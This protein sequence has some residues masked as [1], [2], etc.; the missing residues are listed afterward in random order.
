MFNYKKLK[1][2]TMKKEELERE[3][4]NLRDALNRA[5]DANRDLNDMM[6]QARAV[7]KNQGD[8]INQLE[9][10]LRMREAQKQAS[11]RFNDND[12]NY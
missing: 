5:N 6:N 11:D 7:I 3:M 1:Q 2:L 12:R 10:S 4:L 8:R 9:E